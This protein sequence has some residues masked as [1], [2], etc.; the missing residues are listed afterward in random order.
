MRAIVVGGGPVGLFAATLAAQRGHDVL[1]FERRDGS[2]DKA[3]GEGLMPSAVAELQSV[4]VSLEGR[5]FGGIRYLDASGRQQVRAELA[6]GPGLGVRRTRLIEALRRAAF[7][8]GVEIRTAAVTDVVQSYDGVEVVAASGDSASAD[9]VLGCDGLS[10]T[11]R[12][13]IGVEREAS[14]PRRFGL[15]THFA[16]EPWTTDVEVYWGAT[17]EAYVTPVDDTQ[18]GV[19]LLGGRGEPFNDRIRELVALEER[20]RDAPP[21]G[22]VLGAG[23]M[24][25]VAASVVNGRV[26]LVGDAAGY[27]DALTGEGIA[28]GLKS[29]RAAVR[30]AET[31]HLDTYAAEWREITRRPGQLTDALVRATASSTRRRWIVPAASALPQVFGRLV[32]SLA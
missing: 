18:V 12:A 16:V 14:G 8:A 10:S 32:R 24:R 5:A 23:P 9:V 28:V 17:G 13:T 6:N 31:G 4:G 29:A 1:L 2:G 3:C 19:A 26:A 21:V 7:D 15:V 20:L 30:A 25:R 11:V 27:V 22:K